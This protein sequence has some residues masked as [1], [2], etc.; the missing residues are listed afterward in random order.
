MPDELLSI[1][2]APENGVNLATGNQFN[3]EKRHRRKIL[4]DRLGHKQP[5]ASG[6]NF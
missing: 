1:N 3:H 4:R 5:A 6:F 2:T